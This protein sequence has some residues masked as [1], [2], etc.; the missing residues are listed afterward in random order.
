VRVE[1][2]I[3][4]PQIAVCAILGTWP[5]SHRCSNPKFR[6]TPTAAPTMPRITDSSCNGRSFT[7]SFYENRSAVR[8]RTMML[9][10]VDGRCADRLERLR[11]FIPPDNLRNS[12]YGTRTTVEP[13]RSSRA[14]KA[15]R[16]QPRT[17]R[18][19]MIMPESYR[20]VANRAWCQVIDIAGVR[21]FDE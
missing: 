12:S 3:H 20:N 15:L 10:P 6:S 4:E 11:R 17:C 8:V 2:S 16:S 13:K 9:R 19:H 7:P 5:A 18:S 1:T 21:C 14:Q